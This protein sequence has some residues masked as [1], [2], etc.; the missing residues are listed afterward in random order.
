MSVFARSPLAVVNGSGRQPSGW[1][2]TVSQAAALPSSAVSHMGARET[3]GQG[4]TVM[5]VTTHELK[6]CRKETQWPK[7][8]ALLG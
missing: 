8:L 7:G 6:D 1:R 2:A 5:K 3:A 4:G